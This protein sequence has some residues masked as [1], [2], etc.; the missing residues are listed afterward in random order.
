MT[1]RWT[2]RQVLNRS[3]RMALA[4]GVGVPLL[5]ACGGG[6][7]DSGSSNVDLDALIGRPD[8]PVTLPVSEDHPAIADGLAPE[9]GPLRIFNF[10]DYVNPETV[11]AFK[12][13]YGVDVEITSFDTDSESV[14]KLATGQ[15]EVDLQLS[16]AYNSLHRLVGGGLLQPLNRSYLT[17]FGSL[18][19]SFQDPFYDQGSQYT[20]PYTVFATGIGYRAD[21]IDPGAMAA[22]GWDSLWDT[23]Y[24]GL[25]SVIDDVR[26][27]LAL[28]MLRAGETDVNTGDE[29]VIAAAGDDLGELTRSMSIKVTIEGYKDVPE[30]N[31]TVAHCWSGD[32]ISGAANYLPEGTGPEVL[33]FWYPED[34]KGI[35]NNDCMVVVRGAQNPVLAHLFIDFLL[36]PANAEQNFVW[37]GYQPPIA[38]LGADELIAKGLVPENLRNCVLTDETIANGYRLL[39][40]QPDVEAVWENTWSTFTTGA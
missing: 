35:V 21:R 11:E 27:G 2:R 8:R 7:D 22:A 14:T 18:L 5:Q 20:V 12:A 17:N 31:T 24:K 28:P 25:A 6:D 38:G 30:G 37:N 29:A 10:P 34:D 9:A 36:D 16:A 15:V 4:L 40:L 3:A 33:G 1:T 13:K 23:T 32:M 19:P 26:E 39:A